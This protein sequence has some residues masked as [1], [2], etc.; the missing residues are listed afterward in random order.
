MTK[1]LIAQEKMAVA[2]RVIPAV[3]VARSCISA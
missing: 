2:Q 3:L 1:E